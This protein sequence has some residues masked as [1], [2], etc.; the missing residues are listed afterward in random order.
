MSLTINLYKVRKRPNSTYLPQ[1]AD[2][3]YPVTGTIID[4]TGV[5]DLQI[6]LDFGS[7]TAPADFNYLQVKDFER[8]YWVR[9]WEWSPRG[10]IAHATVD[11]LASWREQIGESRQYILRSSSS[12]DG[13]VVDEYWPAKAGTTIQYTDTVAAEG[14]PEFSKFYA[15]GTYI[16]GVIGANST[17]G[18]GAV[19]YYAFNQQMMN[20]FMNR[21]LGGIDWADINASDLA[22]SLQKAILN[23]M[24]YI[25]SCI[26]FPFQGILGSQVQVAIPLG[27]WSLPAL[28]AIKI[29]PGLSQL[30]FKYTCQ[31]PKHPLAGTRGKYLNL[32]PYSRYQMWASP[33][34]N[35]PLDTTLMVDRTELLVQKTV[36]LVTGQGLVNVGVEAPA[37]TMQV[38]LRP[39]QIG[40][41]IELAQ[42]TAD[43]IGAAI[44]A[45][46]TIGGVGGGTLGALAKMTPTGAGVAVGAG[47]I[48]AGAG[49]IAG[50]TSGAFAAIGNAVNSALA[51]V[52]GT[53]SNGSTVAYQYT[54]HLIS[55]FADMVDDDNANMGRPLCKVMQI[56]QLS[57]FVLCENAD[58]AAPCTSTELQM[59]RDYMNSGF[60][61]E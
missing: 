49:I 41:P 13:A 58:F 55:Y 14:A 5:L 47:A 23:P 33:C 28:G 43:Y 53:G 61:W 24:Q 46:G 34:G 50:S 9:E 8:Y 40:V 52:S 22:V 16:L 38:A 27:W 57:G 48:A 45:V 1:T 26:W 56:N 4:G 37:G 11:P 54:D 2:G 20:T 25:S 19:T 10:W 18:V 59:I 29:Q 30:N 17:D 15:Q 51:Q 60:F 35:I 31:I 36:D 44:N 39:C 32:A 12:S 6:R 42:I 21:L 7:T 3:I